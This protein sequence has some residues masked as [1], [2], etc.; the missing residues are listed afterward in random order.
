MISSFRR[1]I[2]PQIAITFPGLGKISCSC[3]WLVQTD[4]LLTQQY[5]CF[6][7]WILSFSLQNTYFINQSYITATFIVLLSSCLEAVKIESQHWQLGPCICF[8][9]RAPRQGHLTQLSPCPAS[10]PPPSTPPPCWSN[11][12]YGPAWQLW[13]YLVAYLQV[14]PFIACFEFTQNYNFPS[15]RT[16]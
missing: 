1:S 16:F 5:H 13:L 7:E 11:W 2:V 10:S 8:C 3:F 9:W 14:L 12:Q 15:D 4:S 6:Q